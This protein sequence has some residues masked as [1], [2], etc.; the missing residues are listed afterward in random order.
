MEL[1]LIVVIE[2]IQGCDV[3]SKMTFA[4]AVLRKGASDPHIV[5][6]LAAWVVC[7][8]FEWAWLRQRNA[9]LEL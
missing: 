5:P 8:V 6:A 9:W 4:A 7:L 3:R 1:S 2:N